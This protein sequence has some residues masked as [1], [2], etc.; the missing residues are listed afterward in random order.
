MKLIVEIADEYYQLLQDISDDK[1]M[2]DTLL[3]K[4]GKVINMETVDNI[5]AGARQKYLSFTQ[6]RETLSQSW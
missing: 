1:L 6:S 3:I 5:T 2:F 4:H